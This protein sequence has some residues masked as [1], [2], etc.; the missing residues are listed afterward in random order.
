MHALAHNRSNCCGLCAA[1]LCAVCLLLS[2]AEP[3][4]TFLVPVLPCCVLHSMVNEMVIEMK[5]S[6]HA[7]VVICPQQGLPLLLRKRSSYGCSAFLAL[8]VVNVLC[9]SGITVP[10][11]LHSLRFNTFKKEGFCR[12]AVLWFVYNLC[13]T[14]YQGWLQS[15]DATIGR[16]FHP[17]IEIN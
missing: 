17:L 12:L 14:R 9:I 15:I 7:P 5:G 16:H 11:C 4:D 8:K 6:Q 2:I 13:Q 3:W 1:L 10:Y